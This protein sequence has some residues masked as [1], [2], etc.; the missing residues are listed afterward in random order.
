MDT[1]IQ[2]G[3]ERFLEFVQSLFQRTLE[4]SVMAAHVERFPV[5]QLRP[6]RTYTMNNCCCYSTEVRSQWRGQWSQWRKRTY[7][8]YH[9]CPQHRLRVMTV[10]RT[11]TPIVCSVVVAIA[12]EFTIKCW[13][14]A[15]R[16]GHRWHSVALIVAVWPSSV[17]A[18]ALFFV[19]S[20]I[21]SIL[22]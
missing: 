20:S 19:L 18:V 3:H 13:E 2:G 6:T 8:L 14:W 7:S 5:V 21:F 12:L 11:M 9:S 17:S 4:S 16:R 10:Y 22:R 1:I 15:I